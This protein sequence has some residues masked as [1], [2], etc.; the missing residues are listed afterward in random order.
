M[1]RFRLAPPILN[2]ELFMISNA[3]AQAAAGSAAATPQSSLLTFLPIMGM[4]AVL[5]FLMIRPQ[6]KRAKEQRAMLDSIKVGDEVIAAGIMGKVV[7]MDEAYINLELAPGNIIVVQ[8]PSIST[9][10][11]NG[12]LHNLLK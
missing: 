4:F 10:L 3:Y 1:S 7:K 5:Y 9:L 2:S 11:P 8:K 12:T 6:Q